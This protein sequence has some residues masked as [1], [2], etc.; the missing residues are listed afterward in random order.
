MPTSTVRDVGRL[1]RRS[2]LV[3]L[4][5]CNAALVAAAWGAE[6]SAETVRRS[7]R[8]AGGAGTGT[9]FH[10]D[11]K[12]SV[13]YLASDELEGRGLGTKGLDKAADFIA[14]N[15]SKLGLKPPPGQDD[16]FQH[17][18]MTTVVRPGKQ[19]ALSF[20]TGDGEEAQTYE[21][22][23]QYTPLSFSAEKTFEA[24]LA[25]VGYSVTSPDNHYNDYEDI[26]VHGKVALALRY[27]PHDNQ[28]HS[29]F[30]GKDD[31]SPDATLARKA[32]A[33]AEAGA[34]ALVLVNPP[35]FHE[36]DDP[37]VP[38]AR[39]YRGDAGKI[40]VI[41]VKRTVAESWLKAAGVE[42]DL[43]TLQKNIDDTGKPAS[44]D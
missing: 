18:K 1:A 7:T 43:K 12:A 27:E 19:T 32:D 28:G 36:E 35:A 44:F 34:V 41:Q 11:P 14:D 38:F 24:P 13:Y 31:W 15:F 23:E 42:Q 4:L 40:P 22:G 21:M 5:A 6:P 17:F 9:T 2:L 33:A 16:Y 3:A 8:G 10:V 29:R 37:L 25:F 26:D 20:S 30:A 39:M